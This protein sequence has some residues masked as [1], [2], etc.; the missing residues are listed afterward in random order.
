MVTENELTTLSSN[1]YTHT[2]KTNNNN[3]TEKTRKETKNETG[4]QRKK[5]STLS[6]QVEKDN[7]LKKKKKKRRSV[8]T[9]KLFAKPHLLE[10]FFVSNHSLTQ[11]VL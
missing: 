9:T 11:C 6:P 8:E 3:N 10:Y 7:N 4:F 5:G 1:G 2:I